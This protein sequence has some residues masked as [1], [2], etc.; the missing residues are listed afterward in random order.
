MNSMQGDDSGN[1][2]EQILAVTNVF[3]LIYDNDPLKTN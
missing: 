2:N 3:G 1:Q